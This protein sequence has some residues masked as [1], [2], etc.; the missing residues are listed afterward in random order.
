[1]KK[2]SKNKKVV[3]KN[4]FRNNKKTGHPAYIFEQERHHFHFLGITHS[5]ETSVKNGKKTKNIPLI[6]NP[7]PKDK[8][9]AFVRPN[10]EKDHVN[11]FTKPLKDWKLSR[12]DKETINK[13]K[14]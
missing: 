14:K 2:V 12:K 5:S 8:K 11:K 7:N 4:E 9:Q 13:L 1:M 10:K 6:N 3:A